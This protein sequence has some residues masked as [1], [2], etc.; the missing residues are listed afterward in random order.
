[1][2][3]DKIDEL[4]A[5]MQQKEIVD[6]KN[7][8]RFTRDKLLKLGLV[9]VFIPIAILL[10]IKISNG[11]TISKR[12]IYPDDNSMKK[13]MQGTWAWVEDHVYAS[14]YTIDDDQLIWIVDDEHIFSVGTITWH[15]DEGYFESYDEKFEVKKGGKRI[16][17]LD[18]YKNEY[19]KI[20]PDLSEVRCSWCGKVIRYNNTNIHSKEV[21]NGNTLECEYCGHKTNFK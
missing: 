9:I 10:Y 7:T 20:T 11:I 8:F 13:Q 5:E 2:G 19:E 14:K 15:P 4:E 16:V 12:E 18:N 3:F 17:S 1:M 6:R 21:L